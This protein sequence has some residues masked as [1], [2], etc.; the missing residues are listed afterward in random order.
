MSIFKKLICILL[1][2]KSSLFLGQEKVDLSQLPLDSIR[3]SI[4]KYLYSDLTKAIQASEAYILKAK[5]EKNLKQEYLGIEALSTS[6][7][8]HRKYVLAR[9]HF[10]K[11]LKFAEDNKLEEQIIS[12]HILGSQVEMLVPDASKALEQLNLALDMAEKI[13]NESYRE[14]V[15]MQ[16]SYMLQLSGDTQ[17]AIDIRK[18]T[19]SIYKSKQLDSVY[20]ATSQKDVLVTCYSMLS[21]SFLKIKQAD[22][23]KHYAR[24]MSDL[25]APKDSCNLRM[26]YVTQGEIDFYEGKFTSAKE[27]FKNALKICDPNVPLIDLR[28]AYNVGKTDHGEGN[29]KEAKI[30]L[31]EGLDNYQ[32]SPSEEGYMDNYYMLLADCY[33]ETGDLK[34]ANYYFEKY[35]NSTSEFDRIKSDLKASTKAQ[36]IE[37]FKSELKTLETEKDKNQTYLNYLFLAASIIILGLLFV[38]LH[39]YRNKRKNETKFEELLEKMKDSSEDKLN[40]IDTKDEVLEEKNSTDV[41]EEIKQQILIGLKKLEEKE[42]YLKQE[43]NSYNVAKKINTN[44]SYLSKVINSHYGKNFNTYINDLRINYTIVRLKND[45]IFRSYSI[46][47]IAEEVGYKSADSFTKYFKKDTGLNPSFYIKEIKNIA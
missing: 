31:Q 27:N 1:L 9:E 3:D 4:Q 28:M 42:Y 36:E 20:T 14:G 23:A 46:Q 35:I 47:S 24:A 30:I 33:K 6:Y 38:L 40:I 18:K 34:R 41:P 7:L 45:V 22:S 15:L 29:F 13:D 19:I 32:V 21:N 8:V 25:I 12:A 16:I 5:R 44:T 43:C 17:Q 2:L 39:F 11:T 37:K 26:L 10:E